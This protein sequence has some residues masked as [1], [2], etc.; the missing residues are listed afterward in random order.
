MSGP[1]LHPRRSGKNFRADPSDDGEVS[2][3]FQRGIGITS[4]SNGAG[5]ALPCSLNRRKREGCPAAGSDAENDVVLSGFAAAHY[6]ATLFGVVLADLGIRSQC[7]VASGDDELDSIRVERGWAL[8]SIECGD[9][10]AGSSA[11]VDEASTAAQRSDHQIDS[12]RD[13]RQYAG[14]RSSHSSVFS[15]NQSHNL[16]RRFAIEVMGG[17]IRLLGAK[18]LETDRRLAS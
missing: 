14:D 8:G 18:A 12:P 17:V 5:T 3:A 11:D 4:E 9:A 15:V 2:R 1:S 6:F 7:L 10:A 16:E 13:L